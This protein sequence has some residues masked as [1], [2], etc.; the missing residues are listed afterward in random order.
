MW[1][2]PARTLWRALSHV[3][4]D[5]ARARQP[6]QAM[7]QAVKQQGHEGGLPSSDRGHR[8]RRNGL[9]SDHAGRA[10][11]VTS[12]KRRAGAPVPACFACVGVRYRAG[13]RSAVGSQ[14]GLLDQGIGR[15]E[16]VLS[17]PAAQRVTSTDVTQPLAGGSGGRPRAGG[18]LTLAHERPPPCTGTPSPTSHHEDVPVIK[19]S[20]LRLLLR[21][22]SVPPH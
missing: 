9:G 5:A 19:S 14:V 15:P 2:A 4:D 21:L 12:G 6:V 10:D 3:T 17:K 7:A 13:K 20:G 22:R 16:W 8:G 18:V 11:R 1:R